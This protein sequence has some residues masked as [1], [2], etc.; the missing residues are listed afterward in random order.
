M[1]AQR[2]EQ[3]TGDAALQCHVAA[4]DGDQAEIVDDLDIVAFTHLF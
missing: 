1:R 3:L 2:L 4:D